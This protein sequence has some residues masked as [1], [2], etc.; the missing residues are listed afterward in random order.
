MDRLS[1]FSDLS[2]LAGSLLLAWPAIRASQYLATLDAV[3]QAARSGEPAPHD[4]GELLV[5]KLEQNRN[6]WS[7]K[8]HLMLIGGVLA[9]VLSFALSLA[10]AARP[11]GCGDPA[12]DEQLT[13]SRC[14]QSGGSPAQS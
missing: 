9:L 2:G 5:K 6:R 8:E 7:R 1:L 10:A 11:A 12:Q 14:A 13:E 3:R 4:P